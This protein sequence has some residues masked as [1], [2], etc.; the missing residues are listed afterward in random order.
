MRSIIKSKFILSLGLTVLLIF[1]T[2]GVLRAV[3]MDYN[4]P[5][6]LMDYV[7]QE[8]GIYDTTYGNLIE[9]D[10]RSCHGNSLADRHHATP[11]VV[12]DRRCIVCHQVDPASPSGVFI[13]RDCTTGGCHSQF[14]LDANGWH[15]ATDMSS[16]GNCVTCHNPGL[17]EPI[18]PRRDLS[19]YPPSVVTPTPFSCENCHWEQ[20]ASATGNPDNPGHPSTYSHVNDKGEFMGF[21]EY[22]KPIAGNSQ[23]HHMGF[24]GN[25]ASECYR[26]HSQNPTNPSWDPFNPQLIRYCEICHS[27]A[28]LHRIGPHVQNTN[29][30]E[31][32]GFHVSGSSDPTDY[33]PV[34]YRTW[35]LAGPYLPE[36]EPGFTADQQCFGCHGDN[37][38]APPPPPPSPPIIDDSAA[39]IQP[40]HGCCG[41]I[42]TLRGAYFGEEREEGYKVQLNTGTEWIDMP[43]HAW[44]DTLIEFEVP[45]WTVIAP[46]NYDVKVVTPS[47]ASNIRV[48]TIEN[49]CDASSHLDIDPEEGPCGTW[50]TISLQDPDVGSFGNSRSEMFDDD[51]HGVCRLVDFASSQGSYTALDYRNWSEDSFEV[52]FYDFFKDRLDDEGQRD[53]IQGGSEP[54]LAKGTGMALGKWAVYVKFIYFGDEDASGTL[55]AGDTIFQVISSDPLYFEL[56]RSPVIYRVT[57]TRIAHNNL[58]SIYGLNFG[59][60]QGSGRVRIGSLSE[61]EHPDLGGGTVLGDIKSWS[62][63]II[64]VRVA[65]PPEWA[66]QYKYVWVEKDRFKSNYQ[67][68]KILIPLP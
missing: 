27:I 5:R 60:P 61:A 36:A 58:L 49:D 39:G 45:C 62:N 33:D 41:A 51:Y 52:R 10:C 3:N 12:R 53:F 17:I 13:I 21:F 44:T 67:R 31:A 18:T 6:P 7:P 57:P 64:K 2:L 20:V 37:V 30:W 11:T 25:V 59:Y 8:I 19:L 66:G 4:R 28:T 63:T 24:L 23:T 22:Q 50:I 32:V 40:S 48:F 35:D 68:I 15:H 1:G 38:P 47:G 56:T 16:S 29:G 34:R 43:V 54:T 42:V 9:S 14:D 46:G 26:C 55:S 65:S